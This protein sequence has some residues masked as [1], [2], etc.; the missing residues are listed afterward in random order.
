MPFS[1]APAYRHANCPEIRGPHLDGL[2][3]DNEQM[4]NSGVTERT[5]DER[6]VNVGLSNKQ[7]I[8]LPSSE[9]KK[10]YACSKKILRPLGP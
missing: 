3:A 1:F 5:E 9:K 6:I 4:G 10:F 7:R 8:N 2:S